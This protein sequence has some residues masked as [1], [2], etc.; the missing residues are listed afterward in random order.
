MN[1]EKLTK[2]FSDHPF[3]EPIGLFKEDIS[4]SNIELF[5]GAEVEAAFK[6]QHWKS[7]LEDPYA[8]LG[9]FKKGLDFPRDF[10][11]ILS[12]QAILYYLPVFLSA[13]SISVNEADVIIDSLISKFKS[14]ELFARLSEAQKAIYNEVMK[15]FI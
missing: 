3:E 1:K 8:M 9:T 14:E 2:A 6:G 12:D 5:E 15:P 7:M 4:D 10:I 11:L 13:I